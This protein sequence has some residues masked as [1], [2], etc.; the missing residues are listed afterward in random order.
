MAVMDTATIELT[1]DRVLQGH[2]S[3]HGL[4]SWRRHVRCVLDQ[5]RGSSEPLVAS[6]AL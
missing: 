2:D 3:R 6:P 5:P 1:G 4:S